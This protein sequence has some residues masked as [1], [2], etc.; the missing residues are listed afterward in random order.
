RIALARLVGD[1]E[2]AAH[3]IVEVARGVDRVEGVGIVA[4]ATRGQLQAD[5]GY[6]HV[7]RRLDR[8]GGQMVRGATNLTR[9]V[10]E[11]VGVHYIGD[12]VHIADR[13]HSLCRVDEAQAGRRLALTLPAQLALVL[14]EASSV[15]NT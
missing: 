14:I 2:Q 8:M 12:G 7:A 6:A 15:A 9:A 10:D 4:A 5:I 3:E 13:G 11:Q 1:A